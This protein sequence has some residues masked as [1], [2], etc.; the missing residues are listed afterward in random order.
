[1]YSIWWTPRYPICSLQAKRLCVF[2][3]LLWLLEQV[4]VHPGQFLFILH[5]A[6]DALPTAVNLQ[7]W[8]IQCDMKCSP[9]RCVRPTTAHILSGCPV[10]LSQDCYTYRHD[11]VLSC[12][13]SGLSDFL[14]EIDSMS[15]V[16]LL[17]ELFLL[18]NFLPPRYCC[19]RCY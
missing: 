8:H 13:A 7:C 4:S 15:I 9:S 10:V 2:S 11:Q 5:A 19:P 14:A 6:L 18:R 16:W 3:N 17:R 1:M 12:L